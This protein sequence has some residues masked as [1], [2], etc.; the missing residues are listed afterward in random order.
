[1]SQKKLAIVQL[2]SDPMPTPSICLYKSPLNKNVHSVA[3]CINFTQW[4][5]GEQRFYVKMNQ[6][7]LDLKWKSFTLLKKLISGL[8]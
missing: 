1:M 5:V 4:R 3:R 6:N 7:G 2:R 8:D